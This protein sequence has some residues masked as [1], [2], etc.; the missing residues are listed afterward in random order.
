VVQ[1][2]QAW[3]VQHL[4]STHL[5]STHLQQAHGVLAVSMLMEMSLGTRRSCREC[6]VAASPKGKVNTPRVDWQELTACCPLVGAT[7]LDNS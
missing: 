6:K 1:H 2:L 5:Q 4:Q 7:T 3:Q